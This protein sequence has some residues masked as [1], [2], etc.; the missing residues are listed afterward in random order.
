MRPEREQ[1]TKA[2]AENSP[3][4]DADERL[5]NRVAHTAKRVEQRQSLAIPVEPLP[6]PS[7]A[8][9]IGDG[10]FR[11]F[12]IVL[13]ATVL[14]VL[15]PVILLE[16]LAIRLDSPGAAL[17]FHNR[18]AMSVPTPG[19]D[20]LQRDD[21]RPP[22]GGFEPDR[23]YW[24]PTTFR[25]VKFRTMCHDAAE[26]FPEYYWWRYELSTEQVQNMYYKLQDDPRLTRVGK[27]LRKTTLDELPNLWNVLTGDV[28]LVGPRPESPWVQGYYTAEQMRKFTVKPGLTCLSK[29]YGRGELS[30]GEQ[31]EWDLEYVR[32]RTLW[33]DVK[34]LFRTA[35]MVVA[36]PDPSAATT[37]S[38]LIGVAESDA[39]I[40]DTF[41]DPSTAVT[42]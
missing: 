22:E 28:R 13:S 17:F 20:L 23:L 1:S 6:P 36:S 15:S 31:I 16:A 39:D 40:C 26:R 5:R 30:V 11:V 37:M 18:T 3:G 42:E 38:T 4:A 9:R 34:I 35:W 14:I 21:V 41:S 33:L 19:R 27:W 10:C 7:F 2:P 24:A 12:E 25:F 29:V 8:A 32:T